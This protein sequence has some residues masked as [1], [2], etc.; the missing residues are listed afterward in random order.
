MDGQGRARSI[1]KGGDQGIGTRKTTHMVSRRTSPAKGQRWTKGSGRAGPGFYSV[2]SG[3]PSHEARHPPNHRGKGQK[4]GGEEKSV[5]KGERRPY[6]PWFEVG[7][8][9]GRKKNNTLG[10]E[11]QRFLKG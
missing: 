10:V 8:Y 11:L 2:V 9:R 4:R 5:A 6:A 7:K 1:D 3:R